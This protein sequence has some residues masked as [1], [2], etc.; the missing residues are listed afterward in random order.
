MVESIPGAGSTFSFEVLLDR[1]PHQD[2]VII[3]GI[4]PGDLRLLV[5]EG[6]DEVR[7]HFINITDSFGINTDS[8]PGYSEALE[9]VE[10][11][12]VSGR[13]YDI[14]FIDYDLHNSGIDDIFAKLG[15]LIDKNTVVIITTYLE[16]HRIERLALDNQI[17]RFITKPLFPSS[18]LDVINDVVGTKLK[19]LEIKTEKTTDV[20]DL[21]DVQ[22]LLVEDVEINR[23]IFIALLENTRMKIDVA[24]N[25]LVAVSVF[26]ENPE[27]YDLI[28][29]D[30]QMPEMDGYQA[31]R[32]IREIGHPRAKTIPIIAMTANAFKEDIERCLENGMNDHL[33][34]PIDEKAVI[35]KIARYSK[36]AKF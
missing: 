26:N 14:I 11:A 29:M 34:K 27:K 32:A 25:G 8:A 21:S 33:A 35:E 5:V 3:D 24:E 31:T 15:C 2:T 13:P 30:I 28:I 4:R 1:T 9:L 36:Q 7:K 17:T 22:I 16:L 20:M 18:V 19:G 23:E 6:D 12:G 10:A